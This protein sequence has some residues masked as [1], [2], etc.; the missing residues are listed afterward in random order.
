[1]PTISRLLALS[2]LF[3]LTAC[4]GGA[5]TRDS[6]DYKEAKSLRGLD[7]PPELS[8]PENSGLT[9]LPSVAASSASASTVLPQ[10]VGVSIARDGIERWLVVDADA[11]KL[12]PRLRGF[13]STLGLELQM[14]EPNLGIMETNWAENRADAPAGFLTDWVRS[15]F[16]DAY[17][18]GTRDKYRLRLERGE[19]GRSEIFITHY[20][21]EEVSTVTRDDLEAAHLRWQ[22][23]P[24]NRELANEVMNRLALYLGASEKLAA[25]RKDEEQQA[26]ARIEGDALLI[27]EGFA[28][29][30]RLA[31]IALD[32]MGVV[33]EDRN[34]SRGIYYVAQI[35]LEPEQKAERSWYQK[36]LNLK[37][38][39]KVELPKLQIVL[40]G[41]DSST[42]LTV[43]NLD[44]SESNDA[45]MGE[46]L[47]RLQ[48]ELQ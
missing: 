10:A 34:R 43:R 11:Q 1:M 33:V 2:L 39:D 47:K 36:V 48:Q 24:A 16:K 46:L 37:S 27:N 44:G 45:L 22:T 21:L 29:S 26:R 19:D 32:R 13:W 38:N 30:W 31:G 35:Q 42:R 14:D 40:S 5:T 6:L 12:W 15:V 7:V 20:G 17:S 23:R 8:A 3:T 4:S 25:Q 28:R 18:A 9:E 41:D